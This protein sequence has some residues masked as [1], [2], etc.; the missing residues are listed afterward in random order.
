MDI[1]DQ[2]IEE[3]LEQVASKAPTPGG[4]AVAAVAGAAAAALIEM[5]V[6]LTK[7]EEISKLAS[8]EVK[9]A[10]TKAQK[11]RKE[12]LA[13]ADEDAAAFDAVIAA[14]RLSKEDPARK[15]KIQAAFK[16]AAQ[17]PLQIAKLA[18]EINGMA[19]EILK[20]GNK[21]AASDAKSAVY[22]SEAAKKSALANVEINLASIKDLAFVAKTGEEVASLKEV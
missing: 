15:A 9:K 4:G 6:N 2:K 20:V 14:F 7:T 8:Y 18:K 10:G 17:T 12:L 11:T 5:V 13:L 19:K 3:F 21:N 1:K 16:G 22:L